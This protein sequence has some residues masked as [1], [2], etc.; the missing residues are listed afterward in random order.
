MRFDPTTTFFLVLL[1]GAVIGVVFDRFGGR[2]WFARQVTGGGNAM[3]TGA[4][5]GIAGAFIGYHLEIMLRLGTGAMQLIGA[6][7]G[8]LVVLLLWRMVR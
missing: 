8:A 5:V 1:I 2:G 3:I 6:A 7:V 4:L